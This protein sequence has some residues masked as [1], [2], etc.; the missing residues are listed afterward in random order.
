MVIW[1]TGSSFCKKGT[2][3]SNQSKQRCIIKHTS[4]CNSQSRFTHLCTCWYD[5]LATKTQTLAKTCLQHITCECSSKELLSIQDNHALAKSVHSYITHIIY[6]GSCAHK[7]LTYSSKVRVFTSHL[8]HVLITRLCS[9]EHHKSLPSH[10]EMTN[11]LHQ[12][13]QCW[14][15]T[16]TYS[17]N[18]TIRLSTH[19]YNKPTSSTWTLAKSEHLHYITHVV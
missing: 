15:I 9:T 1:N 3:A 2:N 17:S 5:M 18:S 16:H 13:K 12:S 7:T 19:W 11:F 8:T 14:F 6:K 4:S 10:K